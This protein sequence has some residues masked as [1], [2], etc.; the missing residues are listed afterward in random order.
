MPQFRVILRSLAVAGVFLAGSLAP[1]Q[2]WANEGETE[3]LVKP[4]RIRLDAVTIQ[5]GFTLETAGSEFRVGVT[6]NAVGERPEVRVAI[7]PVSSATVSLEGET[8]L[9][10]LY[11]FDIFHQK[12]VEVYQPIWLSQLWTED[13]DQKKVLKYWDSNANAWQLLPSSRT[14]DGESRV[15][16]AIHLPY[17]IVGVFAAP[18]DIAEYSG[19]ASW[20]DWHGAAMNVVPLG[21]EIE[22]INPATGASAT[23]TVVSTGP[24][25]HGRL[26][27]LPRG[28]FAAIGNLSAGVMPV[29]VR[30]L[31]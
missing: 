10:D 27:D 3:A 9:S 4:A 25:V 12:T 31:P 5:R 2:V 13:S 15:Q 24:F 22:V 18:A 6:P 26:I 29:I 8:L 14:V 28:T 30:V 11:S 23:T 16:G 1:G 20:Y 17:A 7:K 21:T 19:T